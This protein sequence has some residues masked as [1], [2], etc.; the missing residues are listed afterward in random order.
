MCQAA[1][2]TRNLIIHRDTASGL[3]EARRARDMSTD[4]ASLVTR[5]E[6]GSGHDVPRELL[7]RHMSTDTR[8]LIST[9]DNF[10]ATI[11]VAQTVHVDAHT[12]SI[13]PIQHDACSNTTAPAEQRHTGVQVSH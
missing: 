9:R 2:D 4:T 6:R 12:Q 7:S 13:H 10:S 11:P 3:D 5:Q 1:T 8:T